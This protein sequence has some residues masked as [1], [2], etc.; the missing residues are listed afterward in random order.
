MYKNVDHVVRKTPSIK[1]GSEAVRTLR[2]ESTS[3]IGSESFTV[4]TLLALVLQVPNLPWRTGS[5]S[6]N[7]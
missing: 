1:P 6:L 7:V 2:L 4:G 5:Q 3:L